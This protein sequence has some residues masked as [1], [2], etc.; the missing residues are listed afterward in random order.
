M[1][2]SSLVRALRPLETSCSLE[3]VANVGADFFAHGAPAAMPSSSTCSHIASRRECSASTINNLTTSSSC[4]SSAWY[5]SF[6]S[7]TGSSTSSSSSSN[8]SEGSPTTHTELDPEL[9]KDKYG[10]A[11]LGGVNPE[12][13]D[14]TIKDTPRINPKRVFQPGQTYSPFVSASSTTAMTICIARNMRQHTL[15]AGHATRPTNRTLEYH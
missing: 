13:I 7:S 9:L 12:N 1:M 4:S 6:S 5:R 14:P 10:Y 8:S 3:A 2:R 15:L 11:V